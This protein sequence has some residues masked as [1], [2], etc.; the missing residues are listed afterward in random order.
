MIDVGHTQAMTRYVDGLV[1]D[2]H[3]LDTVIYAMRV[4]A[5]LYAN[6]V[7][8][9]LASADTKVQFPADLAEQ[10]PQARAVVR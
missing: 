6:F 7:T 4:T 2:Q 8:G 3:D 1:R 5:E 10:H 9:A